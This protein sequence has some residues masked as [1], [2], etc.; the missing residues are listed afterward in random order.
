M[1]ENYTKM[2]IYDDIVQTIGNTPLVRLRKIERY[3]GLKNELYAKVEFFNPGGSI[4]DR[5]GKYMIEGAKKEGK[6]VEGAVIIEP[7]SGNTGVGLALVAADEGYL[8]VFTMPD[9]MSIE[10]ELLL[11][12]LGAFVIRTPTA[13][14]PSDPNSYYKVAEAV[15]NLIWKKERAISREELREIVEYVQRL[16]R[17]ERLEELE[18]ILEEKVEETPYAYIPNQYFNKYNPIAHY[19]TTAREIWEQTNGE[20]DYLFAG[21]GTGGTITGIGRYL[22]ERKDIKII[23]VDPIGSIYNLVKKGTSLE[24]AVKRAHP[25]L[26]E[27]IGEDLLP[28]T[29]DLNLVDDIVVV[30]DQQAFAMTRFLARKE[31]ILA[32]GSSGAALYGTIK[33]L[34]ENG[35]EGKKAVVIFPDTGRNYLTKIFNDE[36]MLK[37]GFEIDDEKVLEVLR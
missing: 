28:D 9:K 12:A 35:V 26:V 24:E 37:N 5:I 27:G 17:E 29:V 11:K 2:G 10:K 8:T 30:N 3:F 36:W 6:I 25:Y 22:K 21:I 14:S 15:R 31:G 1:E 7:T 34:K 23:G 18:A 33:Y 16:V 4:K 13:V 32:G 20:V 19:E